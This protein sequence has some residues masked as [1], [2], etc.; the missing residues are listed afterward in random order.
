MIWKTKRRMPIARSSPSSSEQA[1]RQI[2]FQLPSG[3]ALAVSRVQYTFDLGSSMMST[4]TG[5]LIHTD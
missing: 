5:S 2:H 4:E 1:N 3:S